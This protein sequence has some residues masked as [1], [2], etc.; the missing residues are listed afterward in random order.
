MHYY[1]IASSE[2]DQKSIESLLLMAGF[3]PWKARIWASDIYRENGK[4]AAISDEDVEKLK[5]LGFVLC[6]KVKKK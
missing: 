1:R 5:K 6:R 4:D 3:P 2:P